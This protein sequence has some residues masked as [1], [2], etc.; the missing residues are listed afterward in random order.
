MNVIEAFLIYI[1]VASLK[2]CNFKLSDLG[3]ITLY[4]YQV[5]AIRSLLNAKGVV[6]SDDS[7]KNCEISTVDKFQGRDMEMIIFS[8]VQNKHAEVGNLLMDRRRVNVAMTRAK[9]KLVILGSLELMKKDAL[10]RNLV[11]LS[12]DRGWV[13]N[14]N[15]DDILA[16]YEGV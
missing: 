6:D 2:L 4:K 9:T 12:V 7:S 13:L 16:P 5:K 1:L 15:D 10:L 11:E 3:V 8:S 14:L